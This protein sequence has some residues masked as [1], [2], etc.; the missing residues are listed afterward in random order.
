M[1]CYSEYNTN[2]DEQI[3]ILTHVYAYTVHYQ[4]KTC[5]IIR[6]WK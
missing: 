2:T 5:S 1:I 3:H 6:F 4:L